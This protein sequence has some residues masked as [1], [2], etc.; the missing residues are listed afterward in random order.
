[1]ASF[2]VTFLI[3]VEQLRSPRQFGVL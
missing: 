1:L 3:S 2:K